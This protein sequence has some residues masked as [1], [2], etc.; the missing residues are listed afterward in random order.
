M[1]KGNVSNRFFVVRLHTEG[2]MVG[3]SHSPEER[4]LTSIF[5]LSRD[6]RNNLS[7]LKVRFYRMLGKRAVMRVAGWYVVKEKDLPEIEME[8]RGIEREFLKLRAEVFAELKSQWDQIEKKLKEYAE[9]HGINVNLERLRPESENF[10]DMRYSITP[11]D[12]EI[13]SVFNLA[14][15]LEKKAQES[16][17]WKAVAERVRREGEK[18]MEQLKKEYEAKVKKMMET[19]EEM[20]AE[21]REKKRLIYKARLAGLAKDAG[22][23]ADMLGEDAVEDLKFRLQALKEVLVEA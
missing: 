14:E 12:L 8:F 6:E 16:Q 23:I 2:W 20:K 22:D 21:I 11:L 5:R 7:A 10:L 3:V 17:E 15:E 18:M 9:S 13:A 4:V 19:V 1:E